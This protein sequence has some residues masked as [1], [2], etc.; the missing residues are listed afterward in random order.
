MIALADNLPLVRLPDQRATTMLAMRSQILLCG[1]K[2]LVRGIVW[3]GGGQVFNKAA[4]LAVSII[5]ASWCH[6]SLS[7]LRSRGGQP[8]ARPGRVSHLRAA[9]IIRGDATVA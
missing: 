9:L 6:V 7:F 4:S 8:A 3:P 5:A 2:E 1:D